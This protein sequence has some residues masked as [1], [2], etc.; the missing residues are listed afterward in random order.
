MV[1]EIFWDIWGT[2]V[3]KNRPRNAQKPKKS[4]FVQ[5]Y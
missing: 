4:I 3:M 2:N 1:F 5:K